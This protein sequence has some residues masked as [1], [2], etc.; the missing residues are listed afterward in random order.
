MAC[1]ALKLAGRPTLTR[2]QAKGGRK[3]YVELTFAL[4]VGPAGPE[5][6]VAMARDVTARVEQER[7]RAK[8]A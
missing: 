7:A 5:G 1:G 2:A 8:S 4:V 3:L 6:A